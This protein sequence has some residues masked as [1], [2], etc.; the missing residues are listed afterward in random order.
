[1]PKLYDDYAYSSYSRKVYG[2]H[3]STYEYFTYYEKVDVI[4]EK[5]KKI[6]LEDNKYKNGNIYIKY[7]NRTKFLNELTC[8]MFINNIV[9]IIYNRIRIKSKQDRRKNS[10]KGLRK[11]RRIYDVLIPLNNNSNLDDRKICNIVLP[12]K[13]NIIN[14]LK[15][16]YKVITKC[17]FLTE[18]ETI[19][20]EGQF[21]EGTYEDEV[22]DVYNGEDDINMQFYYNNKSKYPNMFDI[23]KEPLFS[24]DKLKSY[25]DEGYIYNKTYIKKTIENIVENIEKHVVKIIEKH[26]EE[27]K[28]VLN[29]NSIFDLNYIFLEHRKA[30]MQK[31]RLKKLTISQFWFNSN[32]Y[33]ITVSK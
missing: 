14:L 26:I 1:M 16:K 27:K 8:F 5:F 18:E 21:Y 10:R 7:F 33:T 30:I 22:P 29:N 24:Y 2:I 12:F 4:C 3:S 9:E 11:D 17:I 25:D 31:Y 20:V 32:C 28:F 6:I 19:F 13:N 23:T 15:N